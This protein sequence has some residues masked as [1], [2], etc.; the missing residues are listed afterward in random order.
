MISLHATK[1]FG[2]GEGGLVLSTDDDFMQR[3][4]KI[5]NFGVSTAPGQ[6]LGYNGKQSEYH[7]AVGLAGL[8]AWPERR[9]RLESLT[10][11]YASTLAT[12]DGLE[13]LP[14][15]G[16]GWVSCYCNAMARSGAAPLI[17][18]LRSLGIETRRWW[19]SGVHVQQAYSDFTRDE[20]PATERLAK[21]VFGLP[22]F[23][24]ITDAQFERIINAL[25]TASM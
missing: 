21:T 10:Q 23:H 8:D 9:I 12:L 6:I 7:A 4:N 22:F 14:G 18:H 15:Y 16:Q 20:M 25:H 3:F 1:A 11:R 13:M 2:V 19:Q 5:C 24:D 17:E